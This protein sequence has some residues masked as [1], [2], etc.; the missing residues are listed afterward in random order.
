MTRLLAVPF[1]LLVVLGCATTSL[2]PFDR[3]LNGKAEPFQR[4]DLM[5]RVEN[6]HFDPVVIWA[7][8]PQERYFLGEVQPGGVEVFRIPS[9]ILDI[10]GGPK[11]LAD[12]R[13]SV[14]EQLT[15][16]VD[17]VYA[18][19]V[20]WKIKRHLIPSRPVVLMP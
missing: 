1:L 20:R 15:E 6:E 8:W 13:G 12:P 9:H 4:M 5:V 16:T 17:C 3:P 7:V 11:F 18:H 10:Q 14:N 19:W 2:N